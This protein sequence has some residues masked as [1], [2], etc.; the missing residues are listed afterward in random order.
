MTSS[1]IPLAFLLIAFIGLSFERN[2]ILRRAKSRGVIIQGVHY[3]VYQIYRSPSYSYGG[4]YIQHHDVKYFGEVMLVSPEGQKLHVTES[5]LKHCLRVRT[6]EYK[7]EVDGK[8]TKRWAEW[9]I[10]PDGDDELLRPND[11]YMFLY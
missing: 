4:A 9:R 2:D 3:K 5:H 6:H 10:D 8:W 7:T 1:F 11:I